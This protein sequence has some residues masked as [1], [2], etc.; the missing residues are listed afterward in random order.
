MSALSPIRRIGAFLVRPLTVASILAAILAGI[1]WFVLPLI[2]VGDARPFAEPSVRLAVILGLTLVWGMAAALIARRPVAADRRLVDALRRQEAE[3]TVADR[4][5]DAEV[6]RQVVQIRRRMADALSLLARGRPVWSR[7]RAAYRL[8]FYLVLGPAGAGKTAMLLDAGLDLPFGVPRGFAAGEPSGEAQLLLSD[9]AVFVEASGVPEERSARRAE[10]NAVWLGLLDALRRLRPRQPVCGVFLVVDIPATV[11]LG[12][13]GRRALAKGLRRRLDEVSDRFRARP[14]IY[15]VFTKLDEL[16]GFNAFFDTFDRK[17]RE[18]RLGFPLLLGERDEVYLFEDRMRTE[19]A[20]LARRIGAYEL[21]RLQDEPDVRQRSLIHEFPAQFAAMTDALA[22]FLGILAFPHQFDRP[23]YLRGVFFASGRQG[24]AAIDLVGREVGAGLGQRNALARPADT[25]DAHSR[26]FFLTELIRDLAPA[27]AAASGLSRTARR[28]SLLRRTAL[29]GG[30]ALVALLLAGFWVNNYHAASRY[31]ELASERAAETRQAVKDT[32]FGDTLPP[33][34]EILPI[35]DGMRMLAQLPVPSAARSVE[36]VEQIE[37]EAR[38]AYAAALDRLFVPYLIAGLQVS[39]ADPAT[40]PAA[41]YQELKL[42]LSL[43]GV[44][45]PSSLDLPRIAGLLDQAWL[46]SFTIAQRTSFTNHLLALSAFDVSPKAS[47]PAVVDGARDRIRA[48]TLAQLAYDLVRERPEIAALPTFRPADHA[49]ENATR[50][51]ARTSGE[52]LLAGLPG[53]FTREPF[54]EI[55][56]PALRASADE[57]GTDAWVLGAQAGTGE[58]DADTIQAG[59]LA[60]FSTD[61]IRAYDTL[62][63]EM[64]TVPLETPA[65]GARVLRIAITPLSPVAELIAAIGAQ[66]DLAAPAPVAGAAGLPGAAP[67]AALLGRRGNDPDPGQAITQAFAVLRRAA[68]AAGDKPSDIETALV[69]FGPLYRELNHI[70]TGGN[71]LELGMEPQTTAT[72]IGA[73]IDALPPQAQPLF[74][75]MAEAGLALVNDTSGERLRTIWTSTVLPA[76][77]AATNGRFPF[78]PRA[79]ADT[80]FEDFTGIFG[81]SGQI[82]TFRD[83]YLKNSIDMSARPWR[84]REGR[85]NALG[86]SEASLAAFEQADAIT[87]AFFPTGQIGAKFTAEIVSLDARAQAVRFDV[88]GATLRYAHGPSVPL[89]AQWPPATPGAPAVVTMSPEVDGARNMLVGE[90]AWGLFRLLAGAGGRRLV[91]GNALEARFALA[92]RPVVVK[93]TPTTTQTP[94]ELMLLDKFRCPRL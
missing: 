33:L 64:T 7:H 68:T 22:P 23:P 20:Q 55:T 17:D 49:G 11:A 85:A 78:D 59:A 30:L 65:D 73:A 31:A 16:L 70:A 84:W 80:P 51:L 94:F 9:R 54:R 44:R 77:L 88:G 38:Q 69:A 53:L 56:L 13:E 60:L 72:Q 47:D 93:L 52:S 25:D 66:T 75:R 91:D 3:Q 71:I 34:R 27:E 46:G 67:L 86:V 32:R 62:L 92:E 40:V 37:G 63:S 36:G 12:D 57:I 89:S 6:E 45:P 29:V 18:G 90:G 10:E 1:V 39:L 81:P 35:L 58:L 24:R 8:P 48:Y 83:T 5:T 4:T 50:V 28:V 61:Y 26:P 21:P 15:V 79:E 87:R 43:G 41:L 82:A 74:R 76:C 42:Y 14:P 2:A 19:L